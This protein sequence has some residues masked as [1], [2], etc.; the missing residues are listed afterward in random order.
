M[1]GNTFA[2]I[3][4]AATGT[5]IGYTIPGVAGILGMDVAVQAFGVAGGAA[6]TNVDRW[7]VWN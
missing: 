1:L 5:A 2:S 3:G 7:R 6:F 4:S